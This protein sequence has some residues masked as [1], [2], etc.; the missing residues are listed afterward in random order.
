MRTRRRTR[1]DIIFDLCNYSF[2]ILLIIITGYPILY[3]FWCSLS[4]R[5]I[6]NELLLWPKGFT[7]LYYRTVFA[8][9][10]ILQSVFISVART[11]IGPVSMLLVTVMAGFVMAEKEY[12]LHR[13]FWIFFLI[14]MFIGGGMIPGYLLIKALGL[15]HSFWVY[16][17]P[18]LFGGTFN[19]IL[20]KTYVEQL[21]GE[22]KDAARIDG[23]NDIVMFFRVILPLIVPIIATIGLF[24]AVGHWNSWTDTMLYNSSDPE[25]FTMQYNLMMLV[26]KY[27]GI[28]TIDEVKYLVATGG[29]KLTSNGMRA[30]LTFVTMFPIMCV[31]PL[32]QKHFAKG[33][34][35]GAIK[36]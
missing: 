12:V 16:I 28:Q 19:V 9:A 17:I 7:L 31:Y 3:L 10:S 25:L 2:M 11:I 35:I 27:S 22:L 1:G 5:A 21:P 8:D 13:F 30:C 20:I 15:C 14:P 6:G 34:L 26:N 23:A 36:A 29:F 4:G 18:G 24:S 32:L 33:L